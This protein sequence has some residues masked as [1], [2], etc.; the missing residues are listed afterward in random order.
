MVADSGSCALGWGS[1]SCSLWEV[2]L[3]VQDVATSC[4]MIK[5]E[6]CAG[7]RRDAGH[8]VTFR[9]PP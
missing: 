3:L 6:E 2:C 7:V 4:H 9:A 5:K 8:P 1:A